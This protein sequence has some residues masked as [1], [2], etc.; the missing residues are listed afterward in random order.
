MAAGSNH[1]E[2][3]N[4]SCGTIRERERES[5]WPRPRGLP[6]GNLT[7]QLF[8]NIYLNE[9]D[10]FVKHTLKAAHY[11][12]YTD[13]FVIISDS[14]RY[15]EDFLSPVKGFLKE[16]LLLE[17]HPQKVSI[18][19]P[20]QGIDFLGYVLLS[21]YRQ[22]RTKTRQRMFKKL[23]ARIAEYKG[24]KASKETLEHMLQSCLGVLS[25][26]DA[27]GLSNDL[28]NMFWFWITE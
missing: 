16:R 2:F 11:V 3:L 25:H 13:D 14:R 7:S 17:L 28:K 12:R 21:H 1:R 8:A 18:T 10:Q 27:F 4:E 9:F 15:L 20:H 6:I 5:K 23:K 26:A 24:K 22:V 19:T